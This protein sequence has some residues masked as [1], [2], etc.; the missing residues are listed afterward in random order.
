MKHFV[1]KMVLLVL[2]VFSTMACTSQ[3]AYKKNS[4][5]PASPGDNEMVFGLRNSNIVIS[6]SDKKTSDNTVGDSCNKPHKD[7]LKKCLSGVSA[8]S[9]ASLDTSN[10]YTA[11]WGFGTTLSES[12]VVDTDP[13]MVKSF[14][15]NYKNPTAG[16]VTSAGTGAATG[17][18]IGGPWGAVIG[19]LI[20]AAAA[21]IDVKRLEIEI[22][23]PPYC[24]AVNIEQLKTLKG[25]S[26]KLYLPVTLTYATSKS[27]STCWHSLPNRSPDVEMENLQ[28]RPPLS[29]WFY[30]IVDRKTPNITFPPV[31]PQNVDS[32]DNLDSPFQKNDTYFTT[33]GP[34]KTFPVSACRAVEVQITWWEEIDKAEGGPRMF[35]YPMM[36]ADSDYV[37]AIGLPKKG[38]INLLPVC[39]GYASPTQSS[40]SAVET[41][42]A[43]VKQAQAIKAA[44]DK[45]KNK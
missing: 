3:F 16:I 22:P 19:G 32:I 40:S 4:G 31:L 27:L 2:I 43:I 44:Q 26:A 39:G 18:A 28:G 41:I 33:T 38:T 9:A 42:D 17:L 6:S 37:Q 45:Y 24:E 15:V 13:L 36:V 29:G 20:G 35:K 34:K 25:E 10:F 14:T 1:R 7:V 8:E 12:K 11:K 30:R 21:I 23:V 5:D